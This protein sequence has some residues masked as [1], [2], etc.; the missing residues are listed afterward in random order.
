MFKVSWP[1]GE[2]DAMATLIIEEYTGAGGA[3]QM[4]FGSTAIEHNAAVKIF[5]AADKAV[6]GEPLQYIFG[7]TTFCG[8]RINVEPGVLIPRPETEEMTE[9][10]IKENAGFSGTALDLCT[11]SGC[12][13]VALSVAFSDAHIYAVD[14]SAKALRVASENSAL[15]N[16]RINFIN[17]DI[18]T[19][20]A[21]VFPSCRIII[22][23]PPY[24]RESEKTVMQRNV[25]EHE[26][27]EALFVP[28]NDPLLFYRS[29]AEIAEKKLPEGGMIYLEINEALAQ[30]TSLLFE[31]KNFTD[32]KI[33]DDIRGKN[34]ILKAKMNG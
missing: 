31:G 5:S 20:R 3:R 24:V 11:G 6:S 27:H 13:A 18:L 8:H 14:N 9:M 29:V 32:V 16:A 23:N 7:H 22:C 33:F 34:R 28:D 21:E 19:A 4:A 10:V 1:S 12:I 26:P 2:A 30:E 25:L 17:A 15:N